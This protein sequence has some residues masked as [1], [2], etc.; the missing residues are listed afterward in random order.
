MSFKRDHLRYFVAVA[1]EGQMTRAAKKLAIAQPALSQ[2]ISQLEAELGLTLLERHPR[3]VRL[4]AAGSAFL[5]KARAVVASEESVRHTAES[6]AR[7]SQGRLAVGFV[8]PPPTLAHATLFAAFS[9]AWPQAQLSLH[10]LPFPNGPT[11]AW[12]DEVDVAVCHAPRAEDGI[13]MAP[14]RSDPRVLVVRRGHSLAAQERL[15][16]EDV[17]DETFISYDPSVQADW[18]GFHSLDDHRGAPP[19]RTTGDHART[20]LQMLGVLASSSAVTTLPSVDAQFVSN[21]VADLAMIPITDVAPAAVSL[22]WHANEE[23][24]LVLALAELAS[25]PDPLGP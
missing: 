16:P 13:E 1:D 24:P 15:A 20:S 23:H 10:D 12:L 25:S 2:A 18:A 3:G 7:T 19:A 22:V 4:T 8:G 6:L 21:V 11:K 5:E 14:I 17:L 9:L